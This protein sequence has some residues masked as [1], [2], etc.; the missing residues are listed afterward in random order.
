V[1]ADH[2]FDDHHRG[3]AAWAE[4]R[5]LSPDALDEVAPEGAQGAGAFRFGRRACRG[6]LVRDLAPGGEISYVPPVS[7]PALLPQ[8]RSEL[9]NQLA[10]MTAAAREARENATGDEA[11]SEGKYDTRA[12]EAAYLAGAQAEQADKLAEVVRLFHTFDPPLYGDDEAIG[13]GALVESEHG[14]EIVYYLL[15]PAA[16]GHTVEYDGFDCIVLT[17][18]SQLYQDLLGARSGEIVDESALMVLS[19]T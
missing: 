1:R 5:V 2:G 13:P 8:I 9:E 4:E 17:P 11:R 3:F 18:D 10:V 12:T 16:G 15:A 19:V 14:G 7:K 6:N